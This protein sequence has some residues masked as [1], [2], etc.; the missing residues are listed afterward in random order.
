MDSSDIAVLHKVQIGEI[1]KPR[2]LKKDIDPQLEFIILRMLN[3]DK[4][5]RYQRASDII[6]DI[7]AYMLRNYDRM[8]TPIHL[9]HA[10]Y[11]LFKEEIEKEEIKIDLKPL[12]YKIN[13]IQRIEMEPPT[14]PMT[15]MTPMTPMTS[16]TTIMPTPTMPQ[17]FVPLAEK[18]PL[19][20]EKQ[21][22]LVE[23][24]EDF[25]PL[26]EIEFDDD[27]Q[28]E[29]RNQKTQ[30]LPT[31]S[32]KTTV[33]AMPTIKSEPELSGMAELQAI[34]EE[35]AKKRK[36]FLLIALAVIVILGAIIA[37]SLITGGGSTRVKRPPLK[38]GQ[39]KKIRCQ[40]TGSKKENRFVNDRK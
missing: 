7:H 19:I 2:E 20:A 18:A 12:P 21:E 3:K 11:D 34:K 9:S 28:E 13:R 10:I 16:M 23:M 22:T 39:W 14:R 1:I 8:P 30:L 32:L 6:N 27:D 5:R 33:P 25:H 37:F 29:E 35:E 31:V 36:K 38:P 15:I 26:V 40:T 24:K 17:V 4:T